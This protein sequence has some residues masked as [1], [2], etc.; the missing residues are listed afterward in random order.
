M[1]QGSF[2]LRMVAPTGRTRASRQL[3][4][5]TK[6]RRAFKSLVPMPPAGCY[7]QGVSAID[8]QNV[9][10]QGPPVTTNRRDYLRRGALGFGALA[11]AS[12]LA[13]DG[14]GENSEQ[15]TTRQAPSPLAARPTHFD[16]KATSVI[17]LFMA[18]GPSQVDTFDPKPLLDRLD[19]Q[20]L[21]PSF[22]K[23]QTQQTTEDS[24]LLRSKRRF[25][26]HGESGVVI[27]D[28]FPHLATCADEISVVRSMQT[29]SVVHAPA[30]YQMNT[31]RILM[32]HPSLGSWV[33]YGLGSASENLPAFVVMLDS[34]GGTV[35][36]PPC[37]GA[38]YFPPV[39]QG[40]LFR[41]GPVPVLNLR[42]AGGRTPQRQAR[43]LELL[44]RLN[45]IHRGAHDGE[46]SARAASY[47]LAFRMQSHAPEAVDLSLETQETRSLYGMDSQQTEE[48]GRRCLLA[49][50]LVE[51]GVRFVQ[52]YCGGG[53]GNLT[54][55]GHGDIEENHLRMAGQ[56]DQ[57]VAGLLTDLKRRGLLE[58]TLVIWG[59]EFGR[60]P[61]SQGPKGRD[62]SPF[63]FSMWL[64]GGG[65][66]G[67][68]TVGET[69]EI[70][71]RAVSDC[72]HVRDL[73]ATILNQ[74]G[75]DQHLLTHLHSGRE[76]KLTDTG[77]RL[78]QEII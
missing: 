10:C 71:L 4:N 35:G 9:K 45:R 27:S 61:M 20:P 66:R 17:F 29:D 3:D 16:A 67:G 63:G 39:Y 25:R 56:S 51:R 36:G 72:Y 48:F 33:L 73:H 69:D 6:P 49:R 37:W 41:P 46:L 12:L 70:G 62:H 47:E 64:A 52:L 7:P 78:I 34:D 38:G 60:T 53:P 74:M 65:I 58:Q 1:R 11:F 22:G 68:V 28:L 21:P 13:E 55:D 54:W 31:G 50:R 32:G 75:L 2:R 77:G 8:S 40:T 26:K 76:E 57:P 24:L 44:E 43:N 42:P 15:A 18:G 5:E 59:G 23:V 30:L 19:R 14:W